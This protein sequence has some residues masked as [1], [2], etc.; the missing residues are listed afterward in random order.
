MEAAISERKASK[1]EKV[2]KTAE[3]SMVMNKMSFNNIDY[4]VLSQDISKKPKKKPQPLNYPSISKQTVTKKNKS[5]KIHWK[6]YSTGCALV[7]VREIPAE[8]KGNKVGNKKDIMDTKQLKELNTDDIIKM[9]VSWNPVWIKESKDIDSPPPPDRICSGYPLQPI[10]SVF[11]T[12]EEYRKLFIPV[13]L[14]E[15]WA[16]LVKDVEEKEKKGS[17]EENVTCVLEQTN[18]DNQQE[19]TYYCQLKYLKYN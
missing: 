4:N 8:N 13:I 10:P 19:E 7:E 5:K 15:L 12:F 6:D 1:K 18:S 2:K 17:P 9:V 3:G 14:Y 11:T 16:H